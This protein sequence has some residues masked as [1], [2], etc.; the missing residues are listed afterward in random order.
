MKIQQKTKTIFFVI[1]EIILK[2]WKTKLLYANQMQKFLMFSFHFSKC[3]TTTYAPKM[4]K[5][6]SMLE[7]NKLYKVGGWSKHINKTKDQPPKEDLEP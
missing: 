7:F 5:N 1:F 4:H 3:S 6:S 2:N